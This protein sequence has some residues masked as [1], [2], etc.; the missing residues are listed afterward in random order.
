[1]ESMRVLVTGGAGFIG[2]HITD[3]LI[4]KGHEVRIMDNLEPQVHE[5]KVPPYLNPKAEF[6]KGDVTS[7]EDWNKALEGVEVIFHEAAAVGV[8]QSM[9]Q[10]EKYVKANTL[11]TALLLDILVNKNFDIKKVLVASSMSIYGEGAYKC[12]DCGIVF[13]RLRSEE[14]LKRHEWEVK[15]PRCGSPLTPLPT[16]EEKPLNPTSIYAITKKD[17]E[18]MVLSVGRAYGIPTVALRYFNI[19]GE[20]QSLSNPY[21]GV[22]AVFCSRI[23]NNNPP[24]IYEDG[25][26]SRDFVSIKDIVNANLLLMEKNR[27][28]WEPFNVGSGKSTT[29]AQVAKILVGIYGKKIKPEIIGKYRAGDIRHCFSDIRKISGLGF[30]PEVKFESGLRQLVKWSEGISAVDR[31]EQAESELKKRG[32]TQ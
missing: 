17:Q 26:Q 18:E 1:M 27:A 24:V 11:G 23:K 9:Y 20:R 25:R 14:Q 3:A 6:M 22:C 13:P 15:C 28:K 4:Q 32:L 12:G 31:F 16:D 5:G 19:F 10:I 21:T 30:K 2:S 8:G 29:I 7:R